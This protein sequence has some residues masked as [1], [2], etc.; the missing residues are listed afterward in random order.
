MH[1]M[2]Y[3]HNVVDIVL[4]HAEKAGATEVRMVHMSIGSGRDIVEAYFD[5]LFRYLARGTVAENAEFAITWIPVTA[6]CN[7][8]GFVF[9]LDMR[10]RETW[11]CP[12][13]KAERDYAIN[14]GM[15]FSISHIDIAVDER[16][17]S[18]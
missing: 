11:A 16:G 6:R 17:A 18:R 1:E 15:E 2:A 4:E 5:K 8:C 7:S 9:P 14:S 10:R 12:A 3:V 13:C